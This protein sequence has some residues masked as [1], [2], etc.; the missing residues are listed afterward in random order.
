MCPN[1][2]SIQEYARHTLSNTAYDELDLA[3]KSSHWLQWE[4]LDQ[5]G[6]RLGRA[7]LGRAHHAASMC[8][9]GMCVAWGGVRV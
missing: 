1:I 5:V 8:A 6:A 4:H 9:A 7:R 3:I 2:T